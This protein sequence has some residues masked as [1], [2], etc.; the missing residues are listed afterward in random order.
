IAIDWVAK[1]IYFID[2][3]AHAIM[4]AT[5]DGRYRRTVVSSGLEQPA[6]IAVDP[7][8][9]RIFWTDGGYSPKVMSSALD[10]TD[11]RSLVTSELISPAGLAIDHTSDVLYWADTRTGRIDAIGLDGNGRRTVWSGLMQP[12][13]LAVQGD[14]LYV[15]GLRN[16][17]VYRMDKLG[18]G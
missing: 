18:R 16:G 12:Y 10:G 2:S 17:T 8:S 14:W 7:I 6:G 1:N 5:A 13:S 4:V 9:G 3:T 11:P 15:S